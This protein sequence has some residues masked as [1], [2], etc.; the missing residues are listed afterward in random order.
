MTELVRLLNSHTLRQEGLELLKLTADFL[1]D[2]SDESMN[3]L[4]IKSYVVEDLPEN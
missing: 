1:E 3:F 2:Y 4:Q